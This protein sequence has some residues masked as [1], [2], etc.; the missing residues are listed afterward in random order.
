MEGSPSLQAESSRKGGLLRPLANW[1]KGSETA[2]LAIILAS[3]FLTA[4]ELATPILSGVFI[5]NCLARG[6]MDWVIPL[7]IG[8]GATAI[9]RSALY[10]VRQHLL[11]RLE[12][13]L[14][15]HS[16]YRFF[17]RLLMLPAS[18]FTGRSRGEIGSRVQI[19]DRLARL[20]ARDLTDNLLNILTAFLYLLAML[21]IDPLLSAIGVA[22][23]GLNFLV[24][25]LVSRRRRLLN[26]EVLEERARLTA[27]SFGGLQAIETIKATGSESEFFA[28]WAGA[29][30]RS[31]GV[32]QRMD[33]SSLLLSSLPNLLSGLST[34]VILGAGAVRVMDDRLTIGMLVAFQSLMSSFLTP[35]DQFVSFGKS[36]QEIEGE[37]RRLEEVTTHPSDS[38]AAVAPTLEEWTGPPRLVGRVEMRDVTFGYEP[39]RPLLRGFSLI[40]EPGKRVALV[41]ASGSGKSTVARLMCGVYRPWGEEELSA[42]GEEGKRLNRRVLLD[43]RPRDQIPRPVLADS[44]A[45]VDQDLFLFEGTV[46]D[47]LTMWDAAAPEEDIVRAAKDACIHQEIAARPGAY[48]S[49]VE[50]GGAN[51]SGGQR[52]RLEIAR[53][54]V[55]NP[56]ILVLDEATSALDAA[57]EERVDEN[58]RRRGCTCLV[59]AHRLSTIRDCDEI[60]VMDRGQIVQ[61]GTHDQL[62]LD[63]QGLYHQL[64]NA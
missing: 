60:I 26:R 41:G 12:T 1:L 4:T 14:A 51:F 48:G 33:I 49:F 40:I 17:R 19:N 15:L 56:S 18:F 10:W 38:E 28:R 7:L 6:Q 32:G 42:V 9:M 59:I 25:W 52:Q 20:V 55:R 37:M 39:T 44:L 2:L 45:V 21:R 61:R 63:A 36:L 11:L 31:L 27:T 62:I 35:I 5:D 58:L 50:E 53:A 3:L 54:L 57:T 22:I 24:L 64:V 29:L 23:A 13:R 16:S 8:L 34:V 46:R 47:N 30:A 43:G